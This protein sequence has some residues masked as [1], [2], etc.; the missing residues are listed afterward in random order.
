MAGKISLSILRRRLLLV[1]GIAKRSRTRACPCL[2]LDRRAVDTAEVLMPHAATGPHAFK[3]RGSRHVVDV[4]LL[5]NA[6]KAGEYLSLFCALLRAR[7]RRRAGSRASASSQCVMAANT[8]VEA[9]LPSA[10][11]ALR[12]VGPSSADE[13]PGAASI[14]NISFIWV[15]F[16]FRLLRRDDG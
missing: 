9:A 15:S 11:L 16:R 4:L 5:Q 13:A 7:C 8:A 1:S 6:V 12:A 2:R 3:R 14:S 10:D